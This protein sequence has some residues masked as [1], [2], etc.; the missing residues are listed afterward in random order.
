M[1]RKIRPCHQWWG[2]PCRAVRGAVG[3]AKK[4]AESNAVFPALSAAP[5]HDVSHHPGHPGLP[6]HDQ[7]PAGPGPLIAKGS[8]TVTGGY[9]GGLAQLT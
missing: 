8:H 2:I 4:A 7:L 5:S 1:G 3:R 9:V 6:K